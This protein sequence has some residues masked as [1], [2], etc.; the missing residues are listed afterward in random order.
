[1]RS[2]Q[3]RSYDMVRIRAHVYALRDKIRKTESCF[4]YMTNH[5]TSNIAQ[6]AIPII[7]LG[8]DV[9]SHPP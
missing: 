1:M 2:I 8:I 4:M 5:D 3:Y 7:G 9:R 6:V